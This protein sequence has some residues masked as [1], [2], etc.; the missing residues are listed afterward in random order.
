MRPA[1]VGSE[2]TADAQIVAPIQDGERHGYAGYMASDG[3]NASRN[4]GAYGNYGIG[5]YNES[6]DKTTD[7]ALAERMAALM[8]KPTIGAENQQYN[9][10]NYQGKNFLFKIFFSKIWNVK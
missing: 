10:Q 7:Q 4:A 3:I 2:M 1:P 9:Y 8:A 6:S 5:G